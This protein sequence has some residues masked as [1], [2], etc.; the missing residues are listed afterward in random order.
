MIS[1]STLHSNRAFATCTIT[2]LFTGQL[3][4]AC[5]FLRP[6]YSFFRDCASGNLMMDGDALY[7]GGFH[8]SSQD[9]D[10]TGALYSKPLR[11]SDVGSVKY[12]FIDFGI[13][14]HFTNLTQPRLLSGNACQDQ[15]V[16]ELSWVTRY[17]PFATDV[18]ILGNLYR[19]TFT[20][21][22]LAHSI[23]LVV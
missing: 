3:V 10:P 1:H 22:S 7:P 17:D 6:T 2:E 11:R 16:P 19:K 20:K 21:V 14:H 15:E 18:F 13:S 12:Y 4:N 8:P 9:R 5:E 23:Y